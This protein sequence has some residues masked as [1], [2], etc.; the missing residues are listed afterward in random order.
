MVVAVQFRHPV[1]QGAAH[2]QPH[3]QLDAF[4]AG[5]LHV[6]QPGKPAEALRVLH[7]GVQKAGVELLVDEAGARSL[8]LVAHAAG[9]PNLHVQVLVEGLDGPAYGLAQFKAAP[10]RR[11]R[12]DDHVDGEGNHQHR[13]GVR[14]V[15]HEGERH[16]EAV[17]HRHVADR[18]EVEIVLNDGLANVP[19]QIRGAH[20]FGHRARPPAL[21]GDFV[22]IPAADGEGGDDVEVE[23]GGVVVIDQ[24]DH[25]RFPL[26]NPAAGELEAGEQRPPVVVG[27]L[28]QVRRR[29][30]G[31][32]MGHGDPGGDL[33]HPGRAL[34]QAHPHLVPTG[35][36]A[37]W[38]GRRQL[39]AH[40]PPGAGRRR[41]SW[42]DTPPGS[43]P[44]WLRRP[45]RS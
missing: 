14:P 13:P 32:N 40:R 5:L 44:S 11:G 29:A 16:G 28:A 24:E 42:P 26:R 19:S 15:E 4:G 1:V 43:C 21:V 2:D 3:H 25:I 45:S 36:D 22:L 9:A 34:R 20:H 10:P 33:S 39:G 35:T 23:G 37:A 12:I 30:D 41:S 6:V 18:G 31:R 38:S 7:H 17:V 27:G 8:Q